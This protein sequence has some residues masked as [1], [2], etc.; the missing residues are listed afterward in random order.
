MLLKRIFELGYGDIM[1]MGKGALLE[2][3]VASEGRT[4]MA[5][6]VVSVP[7]LVYG[8]SNPEM[9]AACGADMITL[10]GFD[11]RDPCVPGLGLPPERMGEAKG[12]IGRFLGVNLEPVP[13]HSDYPEGRR[14]TRENLLRAVGFGFDYVVITGNPNTGV[15]AESVREGTCIA[16]EV[17]GDRLLIVAGKMHGAGN[18]NVYDAGIVREFARAGAGIVLIPAPGTVPGMDQ[19]LAS[20]QIAAIHEEGALA[21]TAMGTS[22]EGSGA[23]IIEQI[24]LM[25][26]M[27]GADIQHI[28]DAGF[29][30]MAPP[31]NIMA[32][33]IAIRGK[34]HTYRRM[35]YSMRK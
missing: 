3:I 34:R 26:K 33:S 6:T 4:V 28:G 7:P 10:N 12:V 25:S 2:T 20:D 15:T 21:L 35:G 22:Q 23:G 1:S 29:A 13:A 9:A 32:L 5:E 30:G 16:A 14:L 18:R 27:A 24:A 17:A 11:F 31:E 19:R 8:V